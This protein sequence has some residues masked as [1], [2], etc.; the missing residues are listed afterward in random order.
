RIK[1]RSRGA[2]TKGRYFAGICIER[3]VGSVEEPKGI[4]A[5]RKAAWPD[6]RKLGRVLVRFALGRLFFLLSLLRVGCSEVL[7]SI[8]AVSARRLLP[9]GRLFHCCGILCCS[10]LQA[11]FG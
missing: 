8:S 9:L 2:L 4:S 7:V 6:I 11:F 3:G 10:Y 5:W 1:P